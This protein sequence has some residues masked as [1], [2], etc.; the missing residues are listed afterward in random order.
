[1]TILFINTGTGPN[2]GNGDTLRTAFN[3]INQNF[4][5]LAYGGNGQVFQGDAPPT[6]A[7]TSTFWYDTIS[8]R[9]Y[10][11]YNGAWVDANP[12]F[13]SGNQ[14]FITTATIG[15]YA[16]YLQSVSLYDSLTG[17]YTNTVNHITNL[18]FDTESAFSVTDQGSGAVL[19]GMNSTFKY[20]DVANQPGLTAI[21][22]DRLAFVAGT[23]TQLITDATPGAQSIKINVLNAVPS[24][25]TAGLLYNDG[26]NK[27]TW[28]TPHFD[29]LVNGTSTL[30]LTTSGNV[31]FNNGTV[32]STAYVAPVDNS[33]NDFKRL[34]FLSSTGTLLTHNGGVAINPSM[35]QLNALSLQIGQNITTGPV[36]AI[37]LATTGTGYVITTGTNIVTTGGTGNGLTV[38]F[39]ALS[40]TLTSATVNNQGNGYSI[41]DIITVSGTSTVA[42][43]FTVTGASGL[44]PVGYAFWPDGT[45]QTTAYTGT[46]AFANVTNFPSPLT[47]LTITN[48][49]VLI[50]DVGYLTSS[51]LA[52]YVSPSALTAG[53]YTATLT[54]AGN[55][56]LPGGLII[57]KN[58]TPTVTI[59]GTTNGGLMASNVSAKP[60]NVTTFNGTTTYVWQF[61]PNGS[62]TWPDGSIQASATSATS[63]A[64]TLTDHINYQAYA[65][66]VMP[67]GSIRYPD[68]T[69]QTTA[70]TGTGALSL[71]ATTSAYAVTATTAISA[72]TAVSLLNGIYKLRPVAAP[73]SLVGNYGDL[74]GD[75][76]YDGS[77]LYV[78][79]QNYVQT[80]YTVY[81]VNSASNVFYIDILQ[82]GSPFPQIG[83]EVH[84]PIGG[85][86]MTIT[87]VTSGVY[88]PYSTPYYRL[89]ESSMANSYYGGLSYI[90]R[91]PAGTTNV[92][93]KVPYSTLANTSTAV[94]KLTNYVTPTVP[95]TFGN[96]SAQ[97]SGVGNNLRIG[98][99]SGVFTATY[100]FTTIYGGSFA[101][102]Q[103]ALTTFATGGTVLGGTS[104]TPGDRA[105]VF[106]TIPAD[107][108][109]YRITAMTGATFDTNFISIEQIR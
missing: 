69:L 17:T 75:I 45:R 8:G 40:G 47:Y 35:G 61:N 109:A 9:T 86:T 66:T 78:C 79:T 62:V 89:S 7:T 63:L 44:G 15:Q 107:K 94:T 71:F 20:I 60:I 1:M 101:T 52:Q 72:T 18:N 49:S 14:S 74:A 30:A 81:T 59:T 48:V 65:L 93:G 96:V 106:L 31:V 4:A 41:G 90:L 51:T 28:T 2:A 5:Q 10:I 68:G 34:V 91:N 58:G 36:T 64:S 102:G 77:T 50:N 92:W 99:V 19:I 27:L 76:A 42:A 37:T 32:Q 6:T 108:T 84:D 100:M 29:S 53:N 73:A 88:G 43:R 103:G 25:S 3:K 67:N 85:P 39:T 38:N 33:D 54:T 11:Y 105:E 13:Q 55:F 21:G 83:W 104:L 82:A 56:V 97:W 70:Y 16:G 24:T 98:A 22:L 87:N 23:G 26:T 46:V 12:S 80:D 57:N 95:V